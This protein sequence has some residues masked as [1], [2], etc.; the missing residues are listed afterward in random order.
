MM[1]SVTIND[2]FRKK[3]ID[4]NDC[5][6]ASLSYLR[7]A[8]TMAIMTQYYDEGEYKRKG[9]GWWSSLHFFI[10]G[11]GVASS[12]HFCIITWVA[13]GGTILLRCLIWEECVHTDLEHHNYPAHACAVWGKLKQLVCTH[14]IACAYMP[15]VSN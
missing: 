2:K 7:I 10:R 8:T 1:K 4:T 9:A 15:S 3:Q 14:I 13:I 5:S 6:M 11:D 12:L